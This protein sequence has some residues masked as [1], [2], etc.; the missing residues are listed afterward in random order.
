MYK[1]ETNHIKTDKNNFFSLLLIAT[2]LSWYSSVQVVAS[3][4]RRKNKSE[5]C[6]LSSDFPR[7]QFLFHLTWNM[8]KISIVLDV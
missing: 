4:L 5:M 1:A 6:I 3:P 2:I 8:S 7:D